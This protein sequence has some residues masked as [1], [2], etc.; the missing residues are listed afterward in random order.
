MLTPRGHKSEGNG[1]VYM[2][3]DAKGGFA[4]FGRYN[5]RPA[6]LGPIRDRIL[7]EPKTFGRLLSSLKDKGL[8]LV[9]KDTLKS[10]PRGGI[11]SGK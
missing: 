1:F 9:R 11:V 3:I 7:D 10:M 4:A 8:D 5:L 6:A 2:Q